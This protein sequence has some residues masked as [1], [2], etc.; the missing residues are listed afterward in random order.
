MS[1]IDALAYYHDGWSY[2]E[3]CGAPLNYRPDLD[4]ALSPSPVQAG[5]ATEGEQ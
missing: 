2:C 4:D 5:E 1:G 3:R